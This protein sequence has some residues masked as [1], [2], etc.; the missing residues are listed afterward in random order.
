MHK[1]V[2]KP[3]NIKKDIH[4]KSIIRD[5]PRAKELIFE[6]PLTDRFSAT[7]TYSIGKNAKHIIILPPTYEDITDTAFEMR[8]L[9]NAIEENLREKHGE[10]PTEHITIFTPLIPPLLPYVNEILKSSSPL[11]LV[12]FLFE[13]PN[14]DIKNPFT[15]ITSIYPKPFTIN[16]EKLYIEELSLYSRIKTSKFLIKY[17]LIT[18]SLL[19]ISNL[20]KAR[21]IKEPTN[22]IFAPI[23]PNRPAAK[24]IYPVAIF[25]Y[26]KPHFIWYISLDKEHLNLLKNARRD[27]LS[28]FKYAKLISLSGYLATYCCPQVYKFT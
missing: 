27:L 25:P 12:P 2:W 1:I 10:I 21:D 23:Y 15:L 16:F 6:I 26:N 3:T 14:S 22:K 11:G 7:Y 20:L 8:F 24:N 19:E 18:D 4:I 5:I 13:S 28:T 17:N 9:L